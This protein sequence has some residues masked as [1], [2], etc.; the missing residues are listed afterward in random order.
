MPKKKEAV[1]A[2]V[3]AKTTPNING[4][5]VYVGGL[6][7]LMISAITMWPVLSNSY[8]SWDDNVYLFNN[9][10]LN[11]PLGAAL[12]HFFSGNFY[13]GAYTPVTMTLIAVIAKMAGGVDPVYFHG[14]S[15]FFHLLNVLLV[16]VLSYGLSKRNVWVAF[17]VAALFGIHP[18]HVE[19]VA[20]AAEL[21]DL[22]YTCFYLAGMLSYLQYMKA[23]ERVNKWLVLTFVLFIMS[24]LS[25]P[26]AVTFPLTILLLHWYKQQKIGKEI[27]VYVGGMTAMSVGIGIVTIVGQG[28]YEHM[29]EVH[30]LPQR[31]V[32]ACYAYVQYY[33]KL[34]VPSGMS[35]F[36]PYPELENGS[37]PAIYY[38]YI[39]PS[40]GIVVA[41][42][43]YRKQAP[44]VTMGVA[45]FT[46][47]ILLVLQI[48][49]PGMSV[50]ADHYTYIGYWGLLFGIV[51]GIAQLLQWGK[52]AKWASKVASVAGVMIVLQFARIATARVG[53][54]E[55]DER[56][57][58]ELLAEQPRHYLAL[59]NM[60]YMLYAQGK[61]GPAVT[62]LME[63][64]RLKKDYSYPYVNLI[65]GA[66]ALND[67]Q[68]AA[69]IADSAKKHVQPTPD[70]LNSLGY[71]A[72]LQENLDTAV[73]WYTKAKQLAPKNRNAYLA[74]AEIYYRK[75]DYATEIKI[76]NEGLS[77]LPDNVVILNYKG[78]ALYKTGRYQEAIVLFDKVLAEAPD[79]KAASENRDMCVA[80]MK[81]AKK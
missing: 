70:I 7:T 23:T 64:I 27:W 76:L 74:L 39:L 20:W 63:S 11:R 72:L 61:A 60:G 68:L 15:L 53:D 17:F 67:L 42:W 49:S 32:I 22:L 69:Q 58:K 10:Q 9:E 44:Y 13:L 48:V 14:A 59:N 28:S 4:W 12:A 66:V 75:G 3:A 71:V 35:I 65:N 45:F 31:L 37:L 36:Y 56:M 25:K 80:A 73:K 46:I 77:H 19:S 51:V 43:K 24:L 5:M 34:V 38:A 78:Y 18:M 33:A 55:N 47:N 21:K 54:W 6:V 26:S 52:I 41:A 62:Y 40:L 1:K 81:E 29:Q 79:Y 8:I 57:A 30:N 16:Y 50:M 2:A